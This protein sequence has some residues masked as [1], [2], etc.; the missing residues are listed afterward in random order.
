GMDAVAAEIAGESWGGR[1]AAGRLLDTT[2]KPA[3]PALRRACDSDD[4]EVRRRAVELVRDIE[5]RV[6]GERRVLTGHAGT[7]LAVALSPDGQLALSGSADGTVRL[8]DVDAG[9]EV[10]CLET[11]VIYPSVV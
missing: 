9:K 8:W 4:A 7:V 3:L 10:R 6:Y 2:D 5:K 1:G 11:G